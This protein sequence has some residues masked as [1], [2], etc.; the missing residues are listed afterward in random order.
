MLLQDEHY[1]STKRSDAQMELFRDCLDACN[2]T[3]LGFSGLK[4]TWSNK[5]D[6]QCNI[7]VRLDRA[8]ASVASSNLF[9]G[10]NVENLI[11]TTSDHY[12]VLI[13]LSAW[14]TH[15]MWPLV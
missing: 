6:A 1:G 3:D 12:V 8:V 14:P 11:T 4:F 2:L 9:E 13:S 7:R 15:L 10:C 5:Q